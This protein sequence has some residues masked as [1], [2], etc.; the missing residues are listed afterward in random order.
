MFAPV[1]AVTEANFAMLALVWL[2]T[3]VNPPVAR[4]I[5][6]AGELLSADLT[7]ESLGHLLEP[8]WFE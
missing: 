6:G 4:E 3:R 8:F 2:L 7:F 5:A 1:T